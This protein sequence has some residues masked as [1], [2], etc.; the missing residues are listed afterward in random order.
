M[1]LSYKDFPIQT[2]IEAF[3]ARKW[4]GLNIWTKIL[5]ELSLKNIPAYYT[6]WKAFD[7]SRATTRVVIVTLQPLAILSATVNKS[8]SQTKWPKIVFEI[9]K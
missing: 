8:Y 7:K 3:T 6:L 2:Y 1:V 9:R 4:I 5:L